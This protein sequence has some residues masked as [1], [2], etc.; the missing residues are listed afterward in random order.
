HS[1][2]L[3][4]QARRGG[5]TVTSR[6]QPPNEGGGGDDCPWWCR[7][8]LASCR[9]CVLLTHSQAWEARDC[10]P[11]C[12]LYEML[13]ARRYKKCPPRPRFRDPAL[14]FPPAICGGDI[15]DLLVDDMIDLTMRL[16]IIESDWTLGG[17]AGAIAKCIEAWTPKF[18]TYDYKRLKDK[19]G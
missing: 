3:G 18:G 17:S 4:G 6:P 2:G 10:E 19:T 16:M 14:R 15:T 12:V 11:V 7:K 8:L 9:S 1:A 13:C 5:P